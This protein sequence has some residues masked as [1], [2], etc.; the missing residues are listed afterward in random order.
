MKNLFVLTSIL[1]LIINP[2]SSKADHLKPK[3][4]EIIS[5][6]KLFHVDLKSFDLRNRDL[7]DSTSIVQI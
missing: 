7:E 3:L 1:S 5:G 6:G 4:R 2:L